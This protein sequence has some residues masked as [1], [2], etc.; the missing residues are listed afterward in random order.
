MRVVTPEDIQGYFTRSDGVYAFSRWGRPIVPVVFGVDKETLGVVKGA[1]EAVV[2]LAGHTMAETDP[3][4][5][6]NLMFFFFRDWDELLHVPNL[7]K[8]IPDLTPLVGRLK[9]ANASQY[10]AF[11]FD[12]DEAIQAC[13]VF[14]RMDDEMARQPAEAIA[15]AQAVQA[16]V[17]WSDTAF[18]KQSALA[19]LPE[20]GATILRPEIADI[21]R[22]AYDSA[23][24]AVATDASH[25][26]RMSARMARPS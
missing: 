7:G 12:D 9:D 24:P 13:F 11:R 10:R 14:V 1:I 2:T 16:I 8:M 5:G 3:E 20:N 26:L 4:L 21:V 6:A 22:V 19:V 25:A 23:M 15:L 17:M 18:S